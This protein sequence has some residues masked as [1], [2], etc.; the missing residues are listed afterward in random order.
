MTHAP[1]GDATTQRLREFAFSD[2][3]F[4]ALRRL[5]KQLTGINLSEQKRELVY[6]RL[7]RRLRALNLS[8]FR[9]YRGLLKADPAELVQF[10]NA[11]TTNLTAF[12]RE[13]HHFD[14][15]REQLLKAR[16]A[17]PRGAR[18]MRIW[19]AGCSSGEEPYSIAMSVL[20]A[21]AEPARWDI[22]ILATDLDS[23]V[24]QRARRGVYAA[25]RLSG[26]GPSRLARFFVAEPA[27]GGR[28]SYRVAPELPALVTF[29]QLN[30]MHQLPMKGPLDAIF[31]RNTVI[32]FD[33]ET[34]RD[35]FHR[36][37]ALQRPGDLLFLGHSESLFKV[38]ERYTLIGRTIYRRE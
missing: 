5:I 2:E 11:I 7:S 21:I 27:A 3:D 13:P 32:Y 28:A 36:L 12:F 30:L 15:L 25:E 29:R 31:C 14:Y 6:G 8:S 22:R 20:E 18:R 35:L 10:T 9:E 16:A 34:Q 1:A 26:M 33:K 37:A 38:S 17:D 24:L 23:D 19:S 4:E